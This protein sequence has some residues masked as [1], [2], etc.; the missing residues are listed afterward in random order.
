MR[1]LG[2]FV[3]AAVALCASPIANAADMPAKAP[4]YTESSKLTW[5]DFYFGGHIGYGFANL[6]PTSFADEL[7]KI[8]PKGFVWGGQFGLDRQYQNLVFGVAV[9]VTSLTGK[10]HLSNVICEGDCGIAGQLDFVGSLR[11][12]I[13]FASGAWLFYGTGGLGIGH[14]VLEVPGAKFGNTLVGWTAGGG[15]EAALNRNWS[16]RAQYL[17]YGFGSEVIA[18]AVP[19]NPK[20][21]L[22]T[23]GVNY[24]F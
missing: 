20:L 8:G 16:I 3:L 1:S 13:G 10:D 15:I 11:A 4:V 14:S 7:G 9:D 2:T 12:R 24:R 17:H 19:F 6:D 5:N 23:L 18:G 22:V 21:D